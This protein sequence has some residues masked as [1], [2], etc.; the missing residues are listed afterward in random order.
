MDAKRRAGRV[1]AALRDVEHAG[2]SRPRSQA[3]SWL[4][5]RGALV[6]FLFVVVF[7]LLLDT[8]TLKHVGLAQNTSG[9]SLPS[10]WSGSEGA[11]ARP[12]S[13]INGAASAGY[14][15]AVTPGEDFSAASF[16]TAFY[17]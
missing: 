6:W 1:P 16:P 10:S 4:W 14:E 5:R 13:L 17:L 11:R 7:S 2:L 8:T 9:N 12:R 15:S 3:V